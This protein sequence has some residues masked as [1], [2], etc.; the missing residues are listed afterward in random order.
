MKWGVILGVLAA[1]I[2]FAVW[3]SRETEEKYSEEK[4][5]RPDIKE[6]DKNHSATEENF[7][8]K[9]HIERI[10]RNLKVDFFLFD[11]IRV[12][13]WTKHGTVIDHLLIT[14][15]GITIFKDIKVSAK[16]VTAT[17]EEWILETDKGEEKIKNPVN[18]NNYAIS[19]LRNIL[20]RKCK[21]IYHKLNFTSVVLF[22]D[23]VKIN[24]SLKKNQNAIVIKRNLLDDLLET[25][26]QKP[27]K[28]TKSEMISIRDALIK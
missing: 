14:K 15:Q 20:K 9:N 22:N 19:I 7:N 3:R 21:E 26:V 1:A 27:E 23:C 16:S 10:L 4:S 12:R 8:G 13:G 6:P 17:P 25:I 11:K 18:M 5:I 24:S 28:L 2:I